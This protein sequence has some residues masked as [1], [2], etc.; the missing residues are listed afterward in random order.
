MKV[1][2]YEFAS[3][4]RFQSGATV[5]AKIV[6]RHLELLRQQCKG[7]LTPLDVVND[8]RHNNSPLHQFFEWN[9]GAAAERY[10]LSQA[11]GLIRSVVAIY[12]E[13]KQP[14]RKVRAFVHINEPGAPHYRSVG[15]AMSQKK[16]RDLVLQQAWREFQSWR[17][18]YKELDEFASLF[19]RADEIAKRLQLKA[20]H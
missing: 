17:R 4:A 3:G 20:E 7:E 10:R 15:H 13:P 1:I 11:R 18:R 16:T 5:D 2:G 8:A 19:E 6:G 12:R 9:D 14:Q